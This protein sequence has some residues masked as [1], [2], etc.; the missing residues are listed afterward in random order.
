MHACMYLYMYITPVMVCG[1]TYLS[2]YIPVCLHIHVWIHTSLN[3]CLYMCMC[4]LKIHHPESTRHTRTCTCTWMVVLWSEV[5]VHVRV[6][7]ICLHS[8]YVTWVPKQ[9]HNHDETH[10][11]Y[12]M[13]LQM[14]ISVLPKVKHTQPIDIHKY[15]Y[16]CTCIHSH[17][18][19]CRGSSGLEILICGAPRVGLWTAFWWCMGIDQ[20]RFRIAWSS[21]SMMSALL[22]V[23]M[24]TSWG[25]DG[26]RSL[27]VKGGN[28]VSSEEGAKWRLSNDMERCWWRGPRSECTWHSSCR[29][30]Y[31]SLSAELSM[32]PVSLSSVPG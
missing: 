28:R 1:S 21:C 4:V 15:M 17:I 7:I 3:L 13:Y 8:D 20:L 32:R 29:V 5:K 11:W 25:A 27:W 26:W 31:P 18:S 22:S 23:S 12:T 19:P 2:T 14:E 30:R 9:R 6:S 24:E 10:I 16:A